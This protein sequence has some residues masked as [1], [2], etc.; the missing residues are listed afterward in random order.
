MRTHDHATI[1]RWAEERNGRPA[2]VKGTGDEDDPGILRIDFPGYSGKEEL[3]HIS[4]DDF[5]RTF[6]ARKLAFVYQ[7][8]ALHG[9]EGLYN[10]FIERDKIKMGNRDRS[11]LRSSRPTRGAEKSKLPN[12]KQ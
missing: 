3:E 8:E 2:C 10:L 11:Q 12:R 4:W 6:E 9:E 7:V 5:F 1:K